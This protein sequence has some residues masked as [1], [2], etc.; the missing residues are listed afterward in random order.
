MHIEIADLPKLQEAFYL[1]YKRELIGNEMGQFHSDFEVMGE[2]VPISVDGIFVG[3]KFFMN[4]LVNC[5]G[6]K[7]LHVRG[8]GCTQESIKVHG[9]SLKL[10]HALFNEETFVFDLMEGNPS[11]KMDKNMTVLTNKSFSRKVKFF[12]PKGDR[13]QYF[14]Y[15]NSK[16]DH[17]EKEYFEEL[18]SF[19]VIGEPIP[20]E[21]FTVGLDLFEKWN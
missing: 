20:T 7:G 11:F 19:E 17:L 6:Q 18:G 9:N 14:D 12:N 10:Y 5:K 16:Q 8:K 13:E 3:K 21:E 15:A 1:E 2:E 4:R